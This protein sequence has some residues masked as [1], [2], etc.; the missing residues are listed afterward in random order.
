M[1]TARRAAKYLFR[2]KIS[3]FGRTTAPREY[4]CLR[5]VTPELWAG[6]VSYERKT[7]LFEVLWGRAYLFAIGWWRDLSYG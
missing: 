2:R 5:A 4:F 7:F 1:F 3:G 6:N